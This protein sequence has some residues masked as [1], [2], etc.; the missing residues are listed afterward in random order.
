MAVL[1]DTATAV[2]S[3]LDNLADWSLAGSSDHQYRHDLVADRAA[4]DVLRRAGLGVVSE[5]SGTH[6]GDAAVVVVLDP[7]D[8]ST[9]ASRGLPWWNTS[10]CAIDRD[11]L[12]AALVVDQARGARFEAVRGAGARLDGRRI[13]PSGCTAAG[14]AV[15]GLN[16]YPRQY[17]GWKQ[18]RALGATALDLCAVAAG[19]LDGYVDCTR[20]GSA[21]WDYL[22][23]LLVCREAGAHVAD[24]DGDELVVWGVADR[25]TPV[26]AATPDLL[27]DLLARR[28][29]MS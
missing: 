22:G 4:V 25:R 12:R 13:G 23:G 24:A 8:G 17:L 29:K 21:P 20:R 15:I 16:G 27:E 7:V 10:L 19:M 6:A 9:N 18:Y 11:G 5:E 14:A 28:A 2:R 3:A 26:A 1:H